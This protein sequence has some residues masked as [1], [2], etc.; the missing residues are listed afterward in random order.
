MMNLAKNWEWRDRQ[1]LR[2]SSEIREEKRDRWLSTEEI[3]HLCDAL[4]SIR[5]NPLQMRFG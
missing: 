3:E 5:T 1:S 2:G 4:T